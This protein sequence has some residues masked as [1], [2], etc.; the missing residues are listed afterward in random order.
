[1]ITAEERKQEDVA[2]TAAEPQTEKRE[3]KS[4]PTK[5]LEKKPFSLVCKTV[6]VLC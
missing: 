3:P 5:L 2:A 6:Q 1:M 4:K